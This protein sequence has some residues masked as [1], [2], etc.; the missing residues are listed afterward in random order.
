MKSPGIIVWIVAL[1]VL[2]FYVVRLTL[3]QPKTHRLPLCSY[4]LLF[5]FTPLVVFGFVF[6]FSVSALTF[7]FVLLIV[8]AMVGERGLRV[9]SR[10]FGV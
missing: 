7:G 2:V 1:S 9:W 10:L 8:L 4:W 5:I 6:S 3:Q